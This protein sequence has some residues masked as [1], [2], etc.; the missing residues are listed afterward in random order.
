MYDFCWRPKKPYYALL[1]GVAFEMHKAPFAEDFDVIFIGG[2]FRTIT[3]LAS[4][5]GLLQQKVAIIEATD[6]LGC[7]SFCDL[8]ATTSS[9]GS[10][11]FKHVDRRGPLGWIFVDPTIGPIASSQFPVEIKLLSEAL[12]NL[13]ISIAEHLPPSSLFLSCSAKRIDIFDDDDFPVLVSLDD[14]RR[15]RARWCV[16][17]TGRHEELNRYVSRWEPK[18]WL[19]AKVLSRTHRAC[20]ADRLFECRTGSLTILGCSH[21]AFAALEVILGMLDRIGTPTPRLPQIRMVHRRRVRLYY[22]SVVAAKREQ[23]AEREELFNPIE[24]VCPDTGKV[25]RDSGLRNSSRELYCSIWRGDRPNVQMY[26]VDQLEG[27]E[28]LLQRSSLIVQ[29]LGYVG[30]FPQVYVN[31]NLTLPRSV[32]PDEEGFLSFQSFRGHSPIAAI[33]VAPTPRHLQDHGVYAKDL[34]ARL[35]C[36]LSTISSPNQRFESRR[37]LTT[38]RAIK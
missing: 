8:T 14:G 12:A 38:Q 15:L 25:F 23:I 10:A 13:G 9:W 28:N 17:G 36:R 21:S 32:I 24:H 1:D 3:F 11:F 4:N 18:T 5:P 33:R 29:A 31:D 37:T 22:D 35:G 7:G 27:A 34:Y 26:L 6:R 30:R 20:L 19:S 2:G 16:L